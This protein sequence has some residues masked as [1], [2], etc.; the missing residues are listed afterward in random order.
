[1][2]TTQTVG[3]RAITAQPPGDASLL[4]CKA[5][6]AEYGRIRVLHGIDLELRAG[7]VLAVLGANGAGKSSL[8]GAISGSVK[9]T[10]S[11][12]LD[13]QAIDGLSPH[14]RATMGLA[15]VPEARRNM[16][17]VLTTAEN[18]DVGLQLIP[19]TQRPETLAFICDL[20]PI[21]KSRSDVPAGML[22]GGEQQML[23][24]GMALGRRPRALLL[25]EPTQGL[26]PAVFDIL[27]R[28]M[29]RLRETGV[30]ILLAEQNLHFAARVAAR[31]VVLL[32]GKVVASGDAEGMRNEARMSALYFGHKSDS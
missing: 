13:G 30:A 6:T 8:L 4:L 19:A 26:A 1:M 7:E 11:T 3:G 25:D 21:L 2:M 24:I 20:F 29:E 23:A 28:A 22:S 5:V 31:Y 27:E 14:R 9:S 10:G 17:R 18:L 12:E 15:F 16:F 32:H